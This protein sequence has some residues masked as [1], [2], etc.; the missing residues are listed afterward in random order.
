MSSK[1]NERNAYGLNLDMLIIM[2]LY[3]YYKWMLIHAQSSFKG[4]QLTNM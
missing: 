2:Y 3:S 4:T 1:H